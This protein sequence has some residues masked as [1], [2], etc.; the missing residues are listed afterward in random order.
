VY[1]ICE[2]QRIY[3][4]NIELNDAKL[5]AKWKDEIVMRKMSVGLNTNIS[6]ENQ[7]Q[8]IK[9]SIEEGEEVYLIIA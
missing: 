8:D 4:R 9:L 1:N 3:L 6:Y 5:V 7:F 2:G